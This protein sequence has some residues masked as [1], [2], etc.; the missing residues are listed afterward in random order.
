M[1]TDIT[2]ADLSDT[3]VNLET[4]LR[5]RS[6]L[7][8]APSVTWW[9]GDVYTQHPAA[10]SEH[11]FGFVGFNIS[12][13]VPVE[14]GFDLLT[15]EAAFYLDPGTRAPLE[16][17]DNPVTGQTVNVLH[18]W[19]DPVNQQFRLDGPRGPF[20]APFTD[21]GRTIVFNLDIPISSP[22]ALP[23]AEW[24]A[25]SADDTYRAVELFQFYSP[26][27]ELLDSSRV[28]AAADCSWV[29]V[30]PWLPWMEMAQRPGGMLFHCRGSKLA[31]YDE[32][33]EVVRRQVADHHP[34]FA[35]PPSE[36]TAPNETSWTYFRRVRGSH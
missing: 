16:R 29:R 36:F 21:L 27:D 17:W 12:R 24:P 10:R 34:E 25:H 13:V 30:S 35:E 1:T 28:S 5:A 8:G 7:D 33:P 18:V 9:T 4:L 31:S 23:V 11:A 3:R 6:S 2:T 15:R 20:R 26:K 19:N 22:S 14:D 32:L